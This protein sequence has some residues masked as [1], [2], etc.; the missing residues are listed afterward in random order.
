ML[1]GKEKAGRFVHNTVRYKSRKGPRR[2]GICSSEG[3]L[4]VDYYSCL[5][6]VSI[7]FDVSNSKIEETKINSALETQR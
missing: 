3:D 7:T 1:A 5:L 6:G 4:Q 2:E